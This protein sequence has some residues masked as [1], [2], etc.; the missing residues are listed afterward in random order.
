[1]LVCILYVVS[2][3]EYIIYKICLENDSLFAMET[4]CT[5]TT[6]FDVN[7]ILGCIRFLWHIFT[8]LTEAKLTIFCTV[9]SFRLN[10]LYCDSRIFDLGERNAEKVLCVIL[11]LANHYISIICNLRN[12]RTKL[13]LEI[14]R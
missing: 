8:C 13:M 2:R 4:I 5:K 9:T 1:M 6:Y 10:C 11:F 14:K 12:P 3:F 7:I